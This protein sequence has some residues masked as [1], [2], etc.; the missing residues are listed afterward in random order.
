[1]WALLSNPTSGGGLGK[2]VTA[3]TIAWLKANNLD[4][5]DISGSNEA[6]AAD[7]LARLYLNSYQG[8]IVVGGDGLVHLA[9][10]RIAGSNLPIALVPAGTGNDFARS[11][12][13]NISNPIA[14]L[15]LI[16]NRQP[17]VVD[18]GKV[19][20]KYFVQILSTGFDSLVNERA[21]QMKHISGR[22]KYNLAILLVL[23]TFKPKRYSFKVDQVQF[24]S[25]AMLIAVANGSSYG[26]GMY[27]TPMANHQDG[28]L[29]V[30]I[31]GPVSKL[32]FLKVFPKVYK[33]SH[34][35]HPA[36]KILRGKRIEI[37]APAI[38]YADGERI[39]EL[40]VTAEIHPASLKVWR[41]D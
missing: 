30:L 17:T 9:I 23:S 22:F 12:R 8:L 26:G 36:V 11:L 33:G 1:M 21:N 38:A 18:L 7:N 35:D 14:N 29:D 25:R 37:S 16:S 2:R 20:E 4:F 6:E 39:G 15:F 13:L 40:P 24:E 5:D 32:E 28:W 27:I 31:L 3:E 34:I 41:N 10:Q 19:G